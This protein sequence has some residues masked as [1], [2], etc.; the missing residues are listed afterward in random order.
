MLSVV[1]GLMRVYGYGIDNDNVTVWAARGPTSNDTVMT[2]L[3]R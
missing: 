1:T 3:T 2:A